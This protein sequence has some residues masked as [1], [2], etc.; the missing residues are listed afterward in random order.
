MTGLEYDEI[1]KFDEQLGLRE[2]RAKVNG[3]AG[4]TDALPQNCFSMNAEFNVGLHSTEIV[5]EY[6]DSDRLEKLAATMATQ[7][8]DAE[9]AH[10]YVTLLS[11]A[12]RLGCNLPD[13][14]F[15]EGEGTL[16]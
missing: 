10:R 15:H 1:A 2:L 4:I 12:M 16:I 8:S 7:G 9:K 11:C 3:K 14:I 13:C 5:R 6:L